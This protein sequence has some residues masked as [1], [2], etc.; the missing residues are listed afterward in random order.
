M[1][2]LPLLFLL[3]AIAA[4]KSETK[5]RKA[6]DEIAATI[7]PSENLNAGKARYTVDVPKGW[8]TNHRTEYGVDFYF[9]TAPKTKDDPNTNIN[10]MTEYMQNLSLEDYRAG[11]IESVK[12]AI[13][14]A[15]II[16]QGDIMANE[17]KGVWYSYSMAPQG[18]ESTLVSYIFPYGGNAYI[19][20]AGTQTKDASRYRSLFDS[21]ATSLKFEE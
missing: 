14:S 8:T 20:T 1:K 9:L 2:I 7:P 4:C 15:S 6:A 17:I 11:S 21:V 16:N 19:I 12:K 3:M 13:P 18:I 10:V 5:Y